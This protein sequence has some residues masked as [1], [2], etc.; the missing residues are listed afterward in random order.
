ML[1]Q[2]QS[3]NSGIMIISDVDLGGF[4][5]YSGVKKIGINMIESSRFIGTILEQC[6][7]A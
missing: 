7:M 2:N 5:S 3:Q 6:P 1:H 4:K